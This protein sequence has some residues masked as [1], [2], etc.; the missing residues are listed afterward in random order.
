MDQIA[1][2]RAFGVFFVLFGITIRLGYWKK[3]YWQSKGGIYG[4]IPL[5]LLFVWYSYYDWLADFFANAMVIYYAVFGLLI[6][7]SV[8]LSV[9]TPSWIKPKW[10]I[11]VEKHPQKILKRMAE[12]AKDNSEWENQVVSQESVDQWAKK[13]AAK[14]H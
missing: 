6:L 1:I 13:L 5:G 2:I 12:E 7:A 8:F 4:Y 14:K 11:W 9:K 3:L 10:I